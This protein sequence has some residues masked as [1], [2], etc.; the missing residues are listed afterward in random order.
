MNGLHSSSQHMDESAFDHLLQ[1]LQAKLSA[2]DFT[3]LLLESLEKQLSLD[4]R[5]TLQ[6]WLEVHSTVSGDNDERIIRYWYTLLWGADWWQSQRALDGLFSRY[7]RGDSRVSEV[8]R[9]FL[10]QEPTL[11]VI[12]HQRI[13][14]WGAQ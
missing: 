8:L 10:G 4:T 11:E 13:R 12:Q 14:H 9:E 3:T 5:D 7:Q 1:T 6:G 2:S